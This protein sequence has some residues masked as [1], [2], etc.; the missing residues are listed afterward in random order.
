MDALQTVNMVRLL[1]DDSI[2][3]FH[4]DIISAINESQMRLIRQYYLAGDERSL[5]TLYFKN[6]ALSDGDYI[7]YTIPSDPT[8]TPTLLLYPR[9]CRIYNKGLDTGIESLT[10]TYLEPQL[11]YNYDKPGYYIDDEFPRAAYY[12]IE[13]KQFLIDNSDPLNP[14]YEWGTKIRFIKQL[15]ESHATLWFIAEPP[16][17]AYTTGIGQSRSLWLPEECHIEVATLAAELLNDY[18]VGERERGE[19]VFENQRLTLT[20]VGN[21]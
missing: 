12:T 2:D 15:Q 10:A 16:L 21:G 7:T 1:L 4:D 9:A 14:V 20:G 3:W 8:A 19:A 11:Y 13:K 18:D 17:F 6:E 5:R